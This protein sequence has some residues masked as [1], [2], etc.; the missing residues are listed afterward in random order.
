MSKTQELDRLKRIGAGMANSMFNLAHNDALPADIRQSLKYQQREWDTAIAALQ[1]AAETPA[2]SSH[3]A[4]APRWRVFEDVSHGWW[5]IEEDILDGNTILYP[6]KINREAI[7]G[8][9]RAHNAA[10]AATAT[11]GQAE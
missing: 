1:S 5:G 10:L 8:V 6:K 11:E 7:D 2:S 4:G 3:L 9:V